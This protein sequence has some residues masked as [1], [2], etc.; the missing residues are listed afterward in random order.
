M[1]L[2]FESE[3]L[4]INREKSVFIGVLLLRISHRTKVRKR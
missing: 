4:V 2:S 3:I 1:F